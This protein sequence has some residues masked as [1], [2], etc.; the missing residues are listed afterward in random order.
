MSPASYQR[1]TEARK[2]SACRKRGTALEKPNGAQK[3]GLPKARINITIQPHPRLSRN[4]VSVR[5]L[6]KQSAKRNRRP[7]RISCHD[8]DNKLE[9]FT[10]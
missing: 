4:S 8:V 10:I 6:E 2:T 1:I 3:N 5:D 9:K 7:E